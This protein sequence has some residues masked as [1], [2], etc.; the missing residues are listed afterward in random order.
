MPPKPRY[1]PQER[2][3]REAQGILHSPV[4]STGDDYDPDEDFV[5]LDANTTDAR[6]DGDQTKYVPPPPSTTY[7]S[8]MQSAEHVWK[9]VVSE[10]E[11]LMKHTVPM[12]KDLGVA[13]AQ[14]FVDHARSNWTNPA[15][16]PGGA[17]PH[18][19]P[20]ARTVAAPHAHGPRI[21]AEDGSATNTT[22]WC[23]PPPS[24][25]IAAQGPGKRPLSDEEATAVAN[26]VLDEELTTADVETE[27]V[28]AFLAAFRRAK[29]MELD[30]IRFGGPV[31]EETRGA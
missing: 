2:R 21:P 12:A 17:A 7:R 15:T 28:K 6:W 31:V 25:H 23:P 1:L 14:G 18:D 19:D 11:N 26:A 24:A 30:E 8:V 10:S 3:S 4:S 22:P 27:A 13:V 9:D 20:D 5:V 16:D 29:A